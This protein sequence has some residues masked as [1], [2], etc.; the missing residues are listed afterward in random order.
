MGFFDIF[1]S[2]KR[3]EL[4]YLNVLYS[5]SNKIFEIVDKKK[6][7]ADLGIIDLDYD[8]NMFDK[9]EV[10]GYH[11]NGVLDVFNEEYKNLI[12][13]LLCGDDEIGKNYKKEIHKLFHFL[14]GFTESLKKEI[15]ERTKKL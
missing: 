5:V 12:V 3:R 9:I 10:I 1:K 8:N 6:K 14:S 11:K 2:R 7:C 15:E 4:E 13:K